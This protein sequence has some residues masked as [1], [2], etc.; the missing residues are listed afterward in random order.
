MVTFLDDETT[1]DGLLSILSKH[2]L[3]AV[4]AVASFSLQSKTLTEGLKNLG[5]QCCCGGSTYEIYILPT[6][7]SEEMEDL[8]VDIG[9]D[10]IPSFQIYKGDKLQPGNKDLSERAITADVVRQ[11]L[12]QA[13]KVG[14]SGGCCAP[15]NGTAV[16]CCPNPHEDQP[17]DA[18]DVLKLVRHAYANTVN[19]ED[20]SCVSV[21][22]N[23]NSYDAEELLKAGATEANLGLGCGNPL[24]FS[25]I[26]KG[27]TVV[28]LGCG[29]G[30]DCFLAGVKVGE[31]GSVIGVDM[32]PDMLS[33]ARSNAKKRLLSDQPGVYDNVQFRLG[34]IEYLPIADNTVDCIISNCV[35]NLSP[36]KSQVFREIYRVLKPGGRIAISDVVNRPEVDIPDELKTAVGLA[37]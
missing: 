29:A 28:D 2:P 31:S 10:G 14:Q 18:A 25:N 21:H 3:S 26:Q 22:P 33:A 24:L 23:L 1:K 35:I 15:S 4:V 19:Q 6:D 11:A 16:V 17:L 27:E 8:A 32:T 30:G 34:E 20:G 12:D 5:S 13:S 9:L 7:A 36:D 37:C